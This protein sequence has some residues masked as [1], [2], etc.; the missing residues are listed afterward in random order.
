MGVYALSGVRFRKAVF[1]LGTVVLCLWVSTWGIIPMAVCAVV[2]YFC[3]RLIHRFADKKGLKRL[4]LIL[5]VVANMAVLLVFIRSGHSSYDVTSI[6]T[7]K[8]A[9]LKLFPVWGAGVFTLH[10]ISYC[11]DI[12]RKEIE[13]EKNFLLVS[14]YICFFPCFSCGPILRFSD[15]SEQLRKP[16]I[17]SGKL[18]EGIKLMLIGFAEK[19][20]L[21]DPMYEMWQHIRGVSI[22]SL[23]AA[24]A[25][26]GIIAFSFA[27]YYELRAYSHIAQG[28]GSM[29]GFELPDNFDL[30]F[31]SAGFNELIKRFACTFYS[32]VRDYFYRPICRNNLSPNYKRC[33]Q[34][35][36]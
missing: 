19:L 20:F 30:P 2:S 24:C 36:L 1:L 5:S 15:M 9:L 25:W 34:I 3:G 18:A 33:R 21:S 35:V 7:G 22:D 28:I 32:W 29:L 26:L 14:Q 13:P 27:F 31:M 10:G 11:M 4:W 8:G 12:Y 23:S 17:T 16:V 6:F